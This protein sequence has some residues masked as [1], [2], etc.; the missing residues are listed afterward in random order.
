MTDKRVRITIEGDSRSYADSADKAKRST[1]GLTSAVTRQ[2]KASETQA[3]AVKAASGGLQQLDSVSRRVRPALSEMNKAV[4]AGGASVD[5]LTGAIFGSIKLFGAWGLAIGV[6]ADLIIGLVAATDSQTEATRRLRGEQFRAKLDADLAIE[7]ARQRVFWAKADR[8]AIAEATQA[9]RDG[10]EAAEEMLVINRASGRPTT[11]VQSEILRLKAQELRITA[12]VERVGGDITDAKVRE[13]FEQKQQ[14]LLG[15]AE[16]LEREAKLVDLEA[17]HTVQKKITGEK[18]K[19]AGIALSDRHAQR[20]LGFGG[21][22]GNVAG[23]SERLR[24]QDELGRVA[25]M[26]RAGSDTRD[27]GSPERAA[28]ERMRALE[29]QRATTGETLSLIAAEEQAR[30]SLLQTQIDA[31]TTGAERE[32]IRSEIEQVQHEARLRRIAV[33][34]DAEASAMAKREKIFSISEQLASS[35]AA[36]AVMSAKTAGVSARKQEA[37]AAGTAGAQA[38]FVGALEQVKAVAA[39]ASFNFVQGAAHQAAAIFAFAQGGMLLAQAGGAGRRGGTSVAPSGSPSSTTGGQTQPRQSI[40]GEDSTI[41]GSPRPGAP[42]SSTSSGGQK[43]GV[44]LQFYGD[45]HS[46]GTPRREWLRTTL[47]SLD[48]ERQ[49]GR[50]R[51]LTED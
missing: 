3:V 39:F 13:T 16:K 36:L 8:E 46:Y 45:F 23:A 50:R 10:I 21:F 32:S 14:L 17:E 5:L 20:A 31:A 7:Q 22:R 2:S 27:V 48:L 44:T 33:E 51:R 6:A 11:A 37:I 34:Q 43:G 9:T 15:Q 19:Q 12:E 1:E 25:A 26:Q 30:R 18:K 40:P 24:F 38:L 35:A 49:G 47:E 42:T 29:L 28:E 41:P 4:K